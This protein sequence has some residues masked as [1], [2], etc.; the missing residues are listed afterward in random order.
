MSCLRLSDCRHLQN[1]GKDSVERPDPSITAN[2]KTCQRAQVL[3]YIE[4]AF[5]GT[6]AMSADVVAL[7]CSMHPVSTHCAVLTPARIFVETRSSTAH[8]FADTRS[9]PG[10][11]FVDTRSSPARTVVDTRSTPTPLTVRLGTELM[12]HCGEATH[13]SGPHR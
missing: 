4:T 3:A 6:I 11:T 12:R 9:S 8:T 10:R 2:R 5:E 13:W 1:P 7:P